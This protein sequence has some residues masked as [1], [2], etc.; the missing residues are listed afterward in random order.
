MKT[1]EKLFSESK[2]IGTRH[3]VVAFVNTKIGILPTSS[4]LQ[5]ICV[6]FCKVH[7]YEFSFDNVS[8]NS[9]STPVLEPDS[10]IN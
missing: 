10:N 6:Q 9:K 7:S 4:Q 8:L 1:D 5:R 3:H 2:I